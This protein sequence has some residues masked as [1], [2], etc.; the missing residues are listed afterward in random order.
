MVQI[1]KKSL[2]FILAGLSVGTIACKNFNKKN[3][4]KTAYCYAS[5]NDANDIVEYNNALIKL[6]DANYSYLKQVGSNL[7]RIEKGLKNPNYQ[8]EFNFIM[9]PMY[10]KPFTVKITPENP[11]GAMSSGDKK[12]FK[13]SVTAMGDQFAKIRTTYKTLADYIKAQDY[14]DDKGT[15]GLA[16]IDSVY[17]LGNKYYGVEDAVLNRLDVIADDAERVTLKNNPLKDYIYALK[18]DSKAISG[19]IK[20]IEANAGNYTASEAKI[21]TSY[22]S[23]ATLNQQHT[24]MGGPKEFH[25]EEK[26][27]SFDRFNSKV[28][29]FLVEARKIMRNA[30][31][32]GKVSEDD[33]HTLKS[34]QDYVRN[35]YNS[36]VD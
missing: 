1:L 16:L 30:S 20:L 24:A 6:T 5:S 21:K 34:Y 3:D 36:F 22:D 2:W 11:P 12:F 18:D 31:A 28:N 4:A 13:D 35:A 29:D 19:F 10:I 23:L 9:E 26:K 27:N 33:I 14:K 7:E 17:A 8:S 25:L 15:K 32:T